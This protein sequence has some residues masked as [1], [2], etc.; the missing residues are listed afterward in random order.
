MRKEHDKEL[1]RVKD[2]FKK[3]V[4]VIDQ[5]VARLRQQSAS[6]QH[7]CEQTQQEVV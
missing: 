6:W 2:E 5:E 4:L 7:K 1:K 3:D